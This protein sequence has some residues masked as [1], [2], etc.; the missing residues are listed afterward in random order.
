MHTSSAVSRHHP[1]VQPSVDRYPHNLVHPYKNMDCGTKCGKH[2]RSLHTHTGKRAASPKSQ[3]GRHGCKSPHHH[4]IPQ[5]LVLYI[6]WWKVCPSQC[7][8]NLQSRMH[9]WLQTKHMIHKLK[10]K[11]LA[12][13]HVQHTPWLMNSREAALAVWL[14]LCACCLTALIHQNIDSF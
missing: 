1:S 6:L 3:A 11:N 4:S 8:T 2:Y 7:F 5:H 13:L 10:N 14:R 12:V 9:T